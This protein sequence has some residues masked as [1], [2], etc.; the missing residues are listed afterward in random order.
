MSNVLR[1]R[2]V[3]LASAVAASV[4]LPALGASSNPVAAA[5]GAYI[6]L[7]KTTITKLYG[8]VPVAVAN[9]CNLTWFCQKGDIHPKRVGY[10]KIARLIAA[11][12]LL[13]L[14]H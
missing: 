7:S 13:L 8:R 11:R 9:V 3:V 2:S 14:A 10:A 6:S 12:Y 1:F 4:G 5:T